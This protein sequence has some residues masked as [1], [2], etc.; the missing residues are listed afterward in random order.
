MLNVTDT[1]T[2]AGEVV[3]QTALLTFLNIAAW[4]AV[5]V[6]LVLI[7]IG[8]IYLVGWAIGLPTGKIFKCA[9]TLI[10]QKIKQVKDNQNGTQRP[11]F[12][13]MFGITIIAE[14]FTGKIM[15]VGLLGSIA[16]AGAGVTSG[17]EYLYSYG[18]YMA[19]SN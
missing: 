9:K 4:I 17:L 6:G 16:A 5:A 2:S 12:L 7:V 18:A 15:F 11:F 19:P 13:S 3:F 14:G 10:G 8:V 1:L